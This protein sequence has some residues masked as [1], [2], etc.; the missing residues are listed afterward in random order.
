MANLIQGIK[1]LI[2]QAGLWLN[3]YLPDIA[4]VMVVCLIALYANGFIRTVKRVVGQRHFIVRTT[5]FVL[6]TAFGLGF[7]TLWGAP[8]MMKLLLLFGVMWLP[9]TVLVGFVLIGVL[10]DKKS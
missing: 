9:F 8:I 6:M 7:I 2:Y 5:V 4:L 3:S 10:A 1:E